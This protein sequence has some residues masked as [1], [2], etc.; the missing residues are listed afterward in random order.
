MAP[1]DELVTP[2]G[3]PPREAA[4][5]TKG[6]SQSWSESPGWGWPGPSSTGGCRCTSHG[7]GGE[8]RTHSSF[9]LLDCQVPPQQR[10]GPQSGLRLPGEYGRAAGRAAPGK[11]LVR[12]VL[13][14]AG[15]GP[16]GSLQECRP[17]PRKPDVNT[18]EPSAQRVPP[19]GLKN[20][21]GKHGAVSSSFCFQ[22][23]LS[24]ISPACFKMLGGHVERPMYIYQFC[25]FYVLLYKNIPACQQLQLFVFSIQTA[26]SWH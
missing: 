12:V 11:E 3:I 8:E 9:S 4:Y 23:H 19:W 13:V 1:S 17:Q 26:K 24:S 20:Q 16:P 22:T 10:L 25:S 14:H 5:Q 6:P 15:H 2:M 7:G 18:T 21:Q